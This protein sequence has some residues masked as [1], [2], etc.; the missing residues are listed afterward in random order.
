MTKYFRTLP[1]NYPHLTYS[2]TDYS[3]LSC[4]WGQ[5]KLMYSEIEYLTILANYISKDKSLIVYI[6]A[7][8]GEHMD[9]YKILFPD[10]EMILYDPNPFKLDKTNKMFIIK[11][12][13]FTDESI[14]EILSIAKERNIIF[15]SDIRSQTDDEWEELVWENM[16]KQQ[17]WGIK[18]NAKYMLL[19]FRLPFQNDKK[20]ENYSYNLDKI[21]DVINI[22]SKNKETNK[23]LYLS[24]KIIFQIYAPNRSTETRLF[25][26]KR[27]DK[28]DLE[29]YN[30]KDYEE[31]MNYFNQIDRLKNYKYKQSNELQNHILG[32]TNTY[33][34]TGEYYIIYKYLK[35]F[36]HETDNI[37]EKT[38]KLVCQI[39]YFLNKIN[40]N[41][42]I[43]CNIHSINIKYK[44]DI[45]MLKKKVKEECNI[46]SKKLTNQLQNIKT[47]KILS[48]NDIN[49]MIQIE[50]NK[51]LI[52]KNIYSIVINSNSNS[53]NINLHLYFM[54]N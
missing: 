14:K 36:K 50:N 13:F 27:N 30:N 9:Y 43:L 25:I 33:D 22:N 49:K 15:I 46:L 6:G 17:E 23:L 34:N 41:S 19:K 1:N 38:I 37:H 47:S 54:Q 2:N 12:E 29:Y 48:N 32:Y 5:R 28:Y 24:G 26:Q 7:A 4:H 39:N 51:K 3:S 52:Y 18:L 21:K 42:L 35:Y 10:I 40:I 31:Q 16:I 45:E 53:S 20:S 44:K 11:N 8:T